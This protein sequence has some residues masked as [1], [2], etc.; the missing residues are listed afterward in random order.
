MT[1]LTVGCNIL[2]LPADH[3]KRELYSSY[4]RA[5]MLG[6]MRNIYVGNTYPDV[7]HVLTLAGGQG[8]G[9]SLAAAVL[10]LTEVL[11]MDYF[12]DS[13]IDMGAGAHKGDQIAS[14]LG[15]FLVELPEAIS[16]SSNS[17][18]ASIKAFLTTKKD[19]GRF[20]FGREH[21]ERLRATYFVTNS[22]DNI[23]LSDHTGNRR[24]L[25]IDCFDDLHTAD[26]R[27]DIDALRAVLPQLYAEA[28]QR[29]VLGARH[30]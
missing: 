30:T 9:K 7:Q 1:A 25:I 12:H 3:P 8:V 26:Q 14:M 6:I 21:E 15:C 22:N 10:G 24:Y 4:G 11:G 18:D 5:V 27:I 29:C 16:L 20:A 19:K 2:N 13:G 23:F 17:T 28:Y